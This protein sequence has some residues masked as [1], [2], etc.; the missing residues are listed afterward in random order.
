M[1]TQGKKI[2]AK[3]LFAN[4]LI[5]YTCT[6]IQKSGLDKTKKANFPL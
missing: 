5:R 3:D 2:G 6:H 4:Q 1:Q